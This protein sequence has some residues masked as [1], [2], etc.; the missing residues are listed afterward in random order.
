M[1]GKFGNGALKVT[2]A[3]SVY[4]ALL[5]FMK[6]TYFVKDIF[7]HRLIEETLQHTNCIANTGSISDPRKKLLLGCGCIFQGEVQVEGKSSSAN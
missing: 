6:G 1:L 5:F 2:H 3:N 4:R 7:K